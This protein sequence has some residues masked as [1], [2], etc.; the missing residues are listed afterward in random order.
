MSRTRRS[1]AL[2]SLAAS[3]A[4]AGTSVLGPAAAATPPASTVSFAPTLLSNRVSVPRRPALLSG[5]RLVRLSAQSFYTQ[6]LGAVP[7]A[8]DSAAVAAYVKAA[9][10]SR[11]G[12]YAG[13]NAYHYNLSFFPVDRSTPRVDVVWTDCNRL[14]FTP[15]GL[16]DGPAYFRNVPVPV[17]AAAAN[18]T[19]SALALYDAAA[20]QIWEFWKMTRTSS[21]AWQACWGGRID[22]ASSNI[23]IFPFPF[24]VS[25]SGLL[26]AGGVITVAEAKAGAINHAMYLGMVNPAAQRFSWPAN[27]TDGFSSDPH[28][29]MEGQRLRLDPSLDLSAYRLT[30]MGRMVAVA[31]QKYGFIVSESSG[32][33]AVATESGHYTQV[34]TGQDPWDAILGGTP[35]YLVLENFPWDKLQALPQ[36]YGKP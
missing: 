15:R 3:A 2:L 34:K 27:R 18:G 35:P 32:A 5:G 9:V 6:P 36:D 25:A 1:A 30:P 14:G 26:M 20:D 12:G 4:L 29:P 22:N 7:L 16:F 24:G 28:A 19:D 21:G 10:D 11:Y 17:A 31:A 8:A 23:G 13:F 33:V